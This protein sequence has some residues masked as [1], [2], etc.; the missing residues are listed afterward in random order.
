MVGGTR[1]IAFEPGG[2]EPQGDE[3]LLSEEFREPEPD[4]T[5]WPEEPEPEPEAP[6]LRQREWLWPTLA[7]VAVVLWTGFFAWAKQ[8]QLPLLTDPAAW[9]GL[10]S[11]WLIPVLLVGMMWLL[12]MRNSRRE[13]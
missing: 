5:E 10:I 8:A 6:P 7:A 12:F 9:P 2:Q 13:A 11:E 1:I 4:A 3:F